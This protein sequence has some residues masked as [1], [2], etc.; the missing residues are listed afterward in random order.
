MRPLLHLL[1]FALLCLLPCCASAQKA[2]KLD[3][4]NAGDFIEAEVP[5][6]SGAALLGFNA[7]GDPARIAAGS[8]MTL[9]GNV[10]TLS[11][12]GGS[13]TLAGLSDVTL[14]SPAANQLLRYNAT[15]GKW[16]N[17]SP[18]FAPLVSATL[19]TPTLISATIDTVNL[20]GATF[21]DAPSFVNG[22]VTASLTFDGVAGAAFLLPAAS[23]RLVTE[24]ALSALAPLASPTFT[25]TVTIP[26]GAAISGYLTT[27]AAAA[28]YQPLD[29][30]LTDLADGSLTGSKVGSGIA[31]GN[32]TSG[33]LSVSRLNSGTG[34]SSTTFW[35]GDGTWATPSGG[36]GGGSLVRGSGTL[37]GYDAA[38]VP[39]TAPPALT[40]QISTNADV[41]TLTILAGTP[42]VF[43]L[44]ASDP[45]D[46]T[47]WVDSSSNS[48]FTIAEALAGY[49]ETTIAPDGYTATWDS[50]ESVTIS[51]SNTGAA[52]Q[53]NLTS[54]ASQTIT[55]G[56]FGVDAIPA[57]G[58]VQEV[59][60][61]TYDAAKTTKPLRL[62]VYGSPTAPGTVA[63]YLKT[64]GGTYYQ[65]ASP[66]SATGEPAVGSHFTEW[67]SGRAA[68][69][70]V[71]RLL[72]PGENGSSAVWVIAERL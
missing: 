42:Y 14:S 26:A 23:G 68:V 48:N 29:A 36:G 59:T 1:T 22:E 8:G 57:S 16:Q 7:S 21:F 34:A 69:S 55:G 4:E 28:A 72:T 64:S 17:W 65:L 53:I 62:G 20:S 15:S 70:L 18:D 35:R 40:V 2:L 63:F 13:S 38:A 51:T 12:G 6:P 43:T 45:M 71:A 67:V 33:N 41:L 52:H 30:D 56:G 24:S 19:T 66:L 61:L 47:I 60:L 31:A 49:M 58:G 10:L 5:M 9:S 32:I 44:A 25:G 54:A 3:I 11:G 27:S 39:A 50:A 37:T 46:G